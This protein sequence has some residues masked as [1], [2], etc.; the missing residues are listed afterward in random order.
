MATFKPLSELGYHGTASIFCQK[1]VEEISNAG[2]DPE[3]WAKKSPSL[4]IREIPYANEVL[5]LRAP[6]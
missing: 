4:C 5:T 2:L 1:N 6:G 3:G